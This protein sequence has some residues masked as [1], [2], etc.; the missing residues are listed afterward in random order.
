MSVIPVRSK[1]TMAPALAML[2]GFGV[3]AGIL[4]AQSETAPGRAAESRNMR[5]VGHSDLQGRAAYKG[6]IHKQNGRYLA[7]IGHHP[8]TERLNPLTGKMEMSGTSIVDVTDPANPGYLHHI[9]APLYASGE[10]IC[11]G[12]DLPKGERGSHYMLRRTTAKDDNRH[13]LWDVTDSREPKFM[14]AVQDGLVSIHKAWWECSTGIAY[15]P[16]Q[17]KGWNGRG[18]SIFDLSDPAHPKFIRHFGVPGS[19]PGHDPAGRRMTELHEALYLNGRVYMAYGTSS[20]GILQ[21][22]DNDKLLKGDPND[23]YDPVNPTDKQLLYPEI[24]RLDSPSFFGVHTA[25]PMLGVELPQYKA[26]KKGSP[27]DFVVSVPESTADE[28]NQPMPHVVT[29]VDI[30]DPQHPYPVSNFQVPESP[31]N[32]CQR[33]GRFGTHATNW[34]FTDVYRNR[35]VWISYFNAGVRGVDVR[36]PY[37][38]VEVAYYIPAVTEKTIPVSGKA[39]ISTNNVDV[40]DRGFV[41]IF[42]KN[43]NGMHILEPT[44]EAAKIANMPRH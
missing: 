36:N 41:Y 6:E 13:E 29:F 33:G 4:E 11:A 35:I 1:F 8:E 7:Y 25:F 15:L 2:L 18:M 28:C 17:P 16:S 31:G 26:W 9:P 10:Q 34:S 37:N 30:T 22:L 32:F 24:G 39:V 12:D 43:G 44:G 42:D 19:Q 40:D 5:L 21:I 38:P 23:P 20:E 3:M 27:R 14:G